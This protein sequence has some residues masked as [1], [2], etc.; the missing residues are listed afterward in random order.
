MRD[1]RWEHLVNDEI[2][3]LGNKARQLLAA[4]ESEKPTQKL[5]TFE[6]VE[7]IWETV[8]RPELPNF[9]T[10][11]TAWSDDAT[12]P[13]DSVWYANWKVSDREF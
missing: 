7:H 9:R 12:P 13:E 11:Q 1:V 2:E 5:R 8:I 3:W 10:M 4:Y 6:Q